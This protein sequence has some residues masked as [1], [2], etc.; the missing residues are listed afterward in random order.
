MNNSRAFNVNQ[1]LIL[2]TG[3]ITVLGAVLIYLLIIRGTFGRF[4]AEDL[5]P[6]VKSL[7]SV[8][9]G[10]YPKVAILN[11]AYTRYLFPD[12]NNW[13]D[14]NIETWKKFLSNSG[15]KFKVI[16]DQEIELS[17]DTT[18]ELIV[19]PVSKSLSDVEIIKLKK[20]LESGG[21]IFA[22]GGTASYS[23]DGKW[24][25]W[26]FFSE[27]L[28][29][30]FSREITSANKSALHTLRGGLPVTA[31]VPTGYPLKVATWDRPI[32]VEVLEPR[33]TQVSFWYNYRLEDGLVREGIDKSAGI[34]YGTYGKGRFVWMGFEINSVLGEQEDYVF[35]ERI[36]NNCIN[37]LTYKPVAYI[38][39]W[40]N[41][42][43]AAAVIAP[44]ITEYSPDIRNLTAVLD[45]AGIKASF[46]LSGTIARQFPQLIKSLLPYGEIGAIVDVGYLNSVNDTLNKLYDF[47][48]QLDA[49][50]Q[51]HSTLSQFTDN[52]A[53]L[54]PYYGLFDEN[55]I[56]AAIQNGFDYIITDSLT[57]RSVPKTI[58]RGDQRIIE[59]TKAARDD[60]EVIRDFN[61]TKPEFQF[62]TYQE[63]IDRILFEGGLY[64][65][66]LHPEYQCKSDNIEVVRKLIVELK[67]KK[68]WITTADEIQNWYRKKD[69]IELRVEK[70]GDTRV[71][72]KIS[73]P[74]IETVNNLVIDIDLNDNAENISL[75]TEI[76][77]TQ[78][79]EFAH[80][81]GSKFLYLY[82][83]DLKPNESRIYYIDYDKVQV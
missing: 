36:Y 38:R 24:R 41:G 70:R 59:M 10:E 65:F 8:V 12:Q 46:F 17:E 1:I 76:I 77:G 74:G 16:S 69:Y 25:G 83:N 19:L 67:E 13:L 63:D 54:I 5:I 48:S 55:T 35:F 28:G 61:L 53:G 56:K 22:T 75:E 27:V 73:N 30:K 79:S 44:A 72:L 78:L 14:R 29:V 37:W 39:D 82:I 60:F 42:Y 21:S 71:V 47:K 26:D 62:Y 7:E 20:F 45:S 15:I 4:Q 57:D 9:L 6:E 66:K 64:I 2:L 33:T 32:A 40:P 11:S 81:R 31:N 68:F 43:L 49:I 80:K 23:S 58:I 18:Y 50:K 51:T 52:I 3:L 34:V